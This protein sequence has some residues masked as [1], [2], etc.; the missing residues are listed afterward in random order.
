MTEIF[1]ART[2]ELSKQ[3]VHE[4]RALLLDAFD[5]DFSDGD[6]AHACGGWHVIAVEDRPLAHAA[7]VERSLRIGERVVRAG[8]VEAVAVAPAKQ[9][10][11]LGRT[12]M[13][14]AAELINAHYEVGALS[15]GSPTFYE[16]LGWERWRGPSF[17]R[18]GD[19]IARTPAED[20]GIMVLRLAGSPA[21]DLTSPICCDER[22]G[23][24][25]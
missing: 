24:D 20:D 11:G 12:V 23:D 6:W 7:V 2:E 15:T 3:V 22:E 13:R 10:L 25:W 14:R 18:S 4:L 1:V 9:G 21:L 5:G 17:V 16:R 19:E 8:Y